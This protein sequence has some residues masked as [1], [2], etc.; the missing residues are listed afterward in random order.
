[1]SQEQLAAIAGFIVKV[2][3]VVGGSFITTL[4]QRAGAAAYTR[5]RTNEARAVS[6]RQE[7]EAKKRHLQQANP[8][9][10]TAVEILQT[11]TR[12]SGIQSTRVSLVFSFVTGIVLLYIGI[13][14]GRNHWLGF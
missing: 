1:M 13:A 5:F 6:R 8:D 14:L 4:G 9:V 10:W 11:D 7:L 12:R 2:V 3:L